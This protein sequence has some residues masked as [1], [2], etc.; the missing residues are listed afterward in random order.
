MAEEFSYHFFIGRG[1]QSFTLNAKYYIEPFYDAWDDV[2]YPR[3]DWSFVYENSAGLVLDSSFGT[4]GARATVQDSFAFD[5][6]ANFV[7]VRALT[8]EAENSADGYGFGYSWYVFD[9]ALE[10]GARTIN[11]SNDTDIIFGGKGADLLRGY[12]D[13]DW[14]DGGGRAD[15]MYGG[16]GDDTYVVN[17]GADKAVEQAGAGLDTVKASVSYRISPFIETLELTGRAD[18]DATGNGQANILAG[19]SGDNDLIGA[20]GGDELI[21][22]GGADSFVYRAI[23]DSTVALAG[24]DL[25]TDFSR[26]QGDEIDLSRIDANGTA[27]GNQPFAFIGSAAFS[28]DGGEVRAFVNAQDRTVVMADTNGDR[29]A[30]FAITLD[31]P[32]V[33]R[34]GDFVL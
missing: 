18:I 14:I 29:R 23:S 12:A 2:I 11:G 27:G 10:T 3:T 15:R 28:G 32:I 7:A 16:T 22:R 33:L 34:E 5:T 6:R 26:A 17:S 21:G 4:A 30:D 13:D 31:D 8:F 24:R 9:G 19:N 20:G 25:I 1:A